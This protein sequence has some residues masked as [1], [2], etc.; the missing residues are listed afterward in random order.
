MSEALSFEQLLQ[1]QAENVDA[2]LEVMEKETSAIASRK[3]ADVGACAKQK[4]TLIQNI[5]LRDAQLAKCPELQSP[6]EEHLAAISHIKASLEKCHQTNEANG[7][8]LQRAQ[9]SMHKLR[10]LFQEAAGKS[11]MTY[12]SEGQASGSRTLGTNVKA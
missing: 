1:A 10:N 7:V 4:L 5:Q 2:L 8:A 12:D 9:L 11:E 6:S 3:A